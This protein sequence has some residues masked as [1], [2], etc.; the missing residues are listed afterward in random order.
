MFTIALMIVTRKGLAELKSKEAQGCV[1][2]ISSPPPIGGSDA[3]WIRLCFYQVLVSSP[4]SLH[5][6]SHGLAPARI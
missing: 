2:L 4:R 1:E 6:L 5:S 3:V